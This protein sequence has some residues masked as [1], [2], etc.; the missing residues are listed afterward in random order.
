MS[1]SDSNQA[2]QPTPGQSTILDAAH[3]PWQDAPHAGIKM[4]LLWQ[5]PES[6]ASTILFKFEPGAK[7]PL[8]RHAGIEQ[9]YVLEGSLVD[10]DG[11]VHAGGYVVRIP[12]SVHQ[13]HAPNGS[14]HISFFSKRNIML[15]DDTVFP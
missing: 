8:H 14:M 2:T 11:A 13:A 4:K 6:G 15:D 10:H 7:T 1:Q 3:M 5:D 12:G 9:T